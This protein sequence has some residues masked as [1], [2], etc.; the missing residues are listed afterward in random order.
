MVCSCVAMRVLLHTAAAPF[1]R[2]M[3]TEVSLPVCPRPSGTAIDL[4]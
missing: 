1:E 3:H 4:P 2:G